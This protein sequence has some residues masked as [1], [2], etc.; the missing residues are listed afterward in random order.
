MLDCKI[1]IASAEP[2]NLE[3]RSRR[4]SKYISLPRDNAKQRSGVVSE[5]LGRHPEA[6]KYPVPTTL[7]LAHCTVY[8]L[9]GFN[10]LVYLEYFACSART[11]LHHGEPHSSRCH[12][13]VRIPP[14]H[15]IHSCIRKERLYK[16]YNDNLYGCS[17]TNRVSF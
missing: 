14:P 3:R 2:Y 12:G 4:M 16:Q 5:P 17:L 6:V 10:R 13:Q 1:H 11:P 8:L 7:I 9:S 15:R